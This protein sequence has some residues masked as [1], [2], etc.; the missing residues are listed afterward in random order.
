MLDE[1]AAERRRWLEDLVTS[2]AEFPDESGAGAPEL[3]L[4]VIKGPAEQV[5]PEL[6]RELEVDL[7]VMGTVARTGIDGFFMG[8]TAESILGDLDCSVLTMKPPGFTSP[9]TLEE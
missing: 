9:V 3:R 4:H 1:E 6:A 7:V 5:V 8:N 2:Y